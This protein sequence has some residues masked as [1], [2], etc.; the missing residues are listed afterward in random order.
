MENFLMNVLGVAAIAA[1]LYGMLVMWRNIDRELDK[2][3]R[4]AKLKKQRGQ[5]GTYKLRRPS[6]CSAEKVVGIINLVS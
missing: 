6:P 3:E 4:E 2:M 5:S 1:M